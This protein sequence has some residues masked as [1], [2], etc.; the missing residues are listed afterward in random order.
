MVHL[1][2]SRDGAGTH[3]SC[4]VKI[5]TPEEPEGTRV[6]TEDAERN[7][8]IRRRGK[9]LVSQPALVVCRS[10]LRP[11]DQAHRI[12]DGL[13][14]GG[15]L[16]HAGRHRDHEQLARRI[17]DGVQVIAVIPMHASDR[18]RREQARPRRRL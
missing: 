16:G 11:D 4:V 18:S 12:G 15:R 9:P 14:R 1:G 7:L 13:G 10:L 6:H 3:A 17:T 5:F 2:V 8:G